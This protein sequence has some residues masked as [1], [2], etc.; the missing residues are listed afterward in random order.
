MR[1][2]DGDRRAVMFGGG[3]VPFGQAVAAESGQVHQVDV[4]N[5]A[6]LLQMLHEAAECRGLGFQACEFIQPDYFL[7]GLGVLGMLPFIS[8]MFCWRLSV[9]GSRPSN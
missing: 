6:A 3:F 5:I 1:V 8:F 9:R 4:L 7:C 2:F